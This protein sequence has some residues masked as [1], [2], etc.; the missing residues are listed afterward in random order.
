MRVKKYTVAMVRERLAEALDAAEQGVPVVIERRGVRYT[1]AVEG[2]TKRR[3]QRTRSIQILDPAVA[4]G[5][6]SWDWT[7]GGVEFKA[8]HRAS[9]SRTRAS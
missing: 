7:P 1:L 6:W 9:S 2:R 5:K 4:R 3:R 8:K